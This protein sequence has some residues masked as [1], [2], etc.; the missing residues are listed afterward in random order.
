ML[1]LNIWNEWNREGGEYE[2]TRHVVVL[3]HTLLSMYPLKWHRNSCSSR[4]LAILGF[5]ENPGRSCLDHPVQASNIV[6]DADLD[7]GHAQ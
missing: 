6:H 2:I 5:S 1:N 3:F 7:Y 4:H